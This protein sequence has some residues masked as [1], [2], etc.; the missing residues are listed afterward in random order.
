VF[1]L[2]LCQ[3]LENTRPAIA[4]R[5]S[6]WMFNLIETV[7]TLGIV[8]VAGTIMLVDLRL[9]GLALKRSPVTDVV[10]RTVPRTLWGFGLMFVTGWCL[11]SAEAVRLY[12]SPAFRIK[13][14]L[15]SLAGLNALIFH[16]TVYR[17]VGGWNA[18]TVP[19]RARMA[20]LLSL[21]LWIGIIAAGRAI[22]YG[23]GYDQ[24]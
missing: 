21:I 2:G 4:L 19:A 15:L 9:L 10:A 20:G 18:E 7:H 6:V 22:A 11:F 8:L 13:L 23:P 1:L 12:N 14:V 24:T 17:K 3:W 5:D 16:M